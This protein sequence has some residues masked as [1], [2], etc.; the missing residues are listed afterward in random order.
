[1]RTLFSLFIMLTLAAPLHAAP[2]EINGIAAV[3]DEDVITRNELER[4]VDTLSKQLSAK[5]TRL[6]PREILERQ[7]LERMI[8]EKL[9][10][11]MAQKRG[12]QVADE[13]LNTIIQDIAK[14]NGLGMKQFRAALKKDGI[15]FA[16]FREQIRN[17][18]IISR[19]KNNMVNSRVN[20]SAQEVDA[21]LAGQVG[22]AKNSSQYHLRHILVA[23]PS[24]ASP[25]QIQE[26]KRK[27]EGLLARLR[28]GEDFRQIAISYSDGPQALE[29][30]D[31]GWRKLAQ[32]PTLFAESVEKMKKDAVS[33]LIRSSGGF[34]ILQ[35]IGERGEKKVMLRQAN[36]R[37]ILIATNKLVSSDEARKRVE[38]LRQRIL[39]GEEFAK[40]AE[41]NSDDKGSGAKGGD[42]GWADPSIYVPEFQKALKETKV[43]TISQPFKTQFGWHI[44]Q[45]LGWRTIDNTDE[46]KRN[47]AFVTLRQRKAEEETQNWLRQL[48]D[49]AYVEYRLDQ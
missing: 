12:I 34:H 40:L 42:L 9:Q 35:L 16:D 17:E 37:H 46:A 48:R 23:L 10:L 25:E 1:M 2:K 44:V 18:V 6:P 41:V 47:E 36:A 22:Q 27:A 4:R 49:Q 7:L 43:K 31:L 26:K 32:L 45:P 20:V 15:A 39:K 3:V 28:K 29:G 11:D 8:V 5:G 21:F 24:N 19:L 38:R 33:P 14:R 13:Q 30:G